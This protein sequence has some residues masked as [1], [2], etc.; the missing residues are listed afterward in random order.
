MKLIKLLEQSEGKTVEDFMIDP[1]ADI[2]VCVVIV[3]FDDGEI[4]AVQIE[5][6]QDYTVLDHLSPETLRYYD[7]ISDDEYRRERGITV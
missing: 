5:C 3:R 7:M 4:L 6:G 1:M 2:G